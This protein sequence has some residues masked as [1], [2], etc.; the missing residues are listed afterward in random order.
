M[1]YASEFKLKLQRPEI[2][3]GGYGMGP[4]WPNMISDYWRRVLSAMTDIIAEEKGWE[5]LP[6]GQMQDISD[7]PFKYP[8]LESILT[9]CIGVCEYAAC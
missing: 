1:T 3:L 5:D 9:Y 2:H 7:F 8:P 6:A 4:L